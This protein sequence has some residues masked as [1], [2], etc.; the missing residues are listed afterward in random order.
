MTGYTLGQGHELKR[1]APCV[2]LAAGI[3]VDA[4]CTNAA[5]LLLLLEPALV[6]RRL[7]LHV[8][9]HL[10]SWHAAVNAR[11]VQLGK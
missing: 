3:P 11:Q 7:H 1:S 4:S 5:Q 9:Q 10:Q 8:Q 2:H 6:G